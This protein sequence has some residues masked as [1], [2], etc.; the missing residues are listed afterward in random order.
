LSLPVLIRDV[1]SSESHPHHPC[2]GLAR[3]VRTS[4]TIRVVGR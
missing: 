3:V 4:N 2:E 1:T